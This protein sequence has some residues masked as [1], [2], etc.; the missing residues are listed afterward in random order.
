MISKQTIVDQIEIRRDG[1]M[2]VR[3]AVQVVEDGN[4]LSS[5]WHRTAFDPST[6]VDQQMA[7]VNAHL[8]SMG[9]AAVED[10]EIDRVRVLVPVVQ[11]DDVKSAFRQNQRAGLGVMRR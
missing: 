9:R 5:D 4:V 8:E 3:F 10:A 6:D 1:T 11:T 2:Q 7:A